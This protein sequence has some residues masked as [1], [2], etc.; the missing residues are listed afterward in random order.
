MS[1]FSWENIQL[2]ALNP[3]DFK[4]KVAEIDPIKNLPKNCAA[5]AVNTLEKL[6]KKE[7][8]KGKK[9]TFLVNQ[10]G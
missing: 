1:S 10:R 9:T 6:K 3:T 4:A 2:I 5:F 8:I 7:L